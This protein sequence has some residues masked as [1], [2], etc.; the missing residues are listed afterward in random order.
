[1]NKNIK[2]N[3]LKI[4]LALIIIILITILKSNYSF[5]LSDVTSSTWSDWNITSQGTA[6]AFT[7]KVNVILG[8]IQTIGII[9]SVSTLAFIGIKFMLGSVEEKAN[10]KQTLIPWIIGASMVFAITTVPSLIY[11]MVNPAETL[12]PG[13]MEVGSYLDGMLEAAKEI[14]N[15]EETN[16]EQ[17]KEKCVE[18]AQEYKI[19]SG[20]FARGKES[21]FLDA[22]T[23]QE[24]IKFAE[25]IRKAVI[26]VKNESRGDIQQAYEYFKKIYKLG[27]AENAKYKVFKKAAELGLTSPDGKKDVISEYT[28][29][30]Y[31]AANLI[32]NIVRT[33]FK[34]LG[35]TYVYDYNPEEHPEDE[36]ILEA[37][38]DAVKQKMLEARKYD[39]GTLFY[40][41]MYHTFQTILYA[42]TNEKNPTDNPYINPLKYAEGVR[43]E[44]STMITLG[45][46]HTYSGHLPSE[47]AYWYGC[48]DAH[49]KADRDM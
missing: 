13:Q 16:I 5:A 30:M 12:R 22:S 9:I 20:D 39:D 2:K 45:A 6:S 37:A 41:G 27:D 31:A 11:N 46:A 29:G 7:E 14:S 35:K 19:L 23:S 42:T 17:I 36:A 21:V 34:K 40:N 24:P 44:I 4:I 48:Y 25:G 47:G 33:E 15:M 32:N 26:D 43:D 38:R 49:E 18:K 28:K 3:I 1:M 8:I 10:Y